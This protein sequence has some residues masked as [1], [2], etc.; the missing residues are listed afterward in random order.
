MDTAGLF[1]PDP[2]P[3]NDEAG[4]TPGTQTALN[5]LRAAVNAN[6]GT[7]RLRSAYRPA[8]YQTHIRE[9]YDKYQIVR[10]WPEG[11]C[12]AVRTNVMAEWRRH[13]PFGARPARNS[14]H[15]SGRAFDANWG[16]LNAG[17]TID[18]LAR[19]CNLSRPLPSRDRTHFV[20]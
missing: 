19:G 6:G 12:S 3:S 16:T 2:W 8:S 5:C 18:D 7:F 11:R 4:L 9:V 15:S 14:L 10:G 13:A 17:A 1:H 20:H